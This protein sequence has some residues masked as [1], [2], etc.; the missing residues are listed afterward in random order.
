MIGKR[1]MRG[2]VAAVALSTLG[3]GVV[4]GSGSAA[5]S[6]SEVAAAAAPPGGAD[7]GPGGAA[8]GPGGVD[9]Q[10]VTT[11]DELV[12]LI[13]DAYGDAGLGLH[14]GHQPVESVLNEVLTI[15]HEELHVRMDSGQNLAAIAEDLGVGTDALVAALVESWS[16]AIDNL[17]ES[18]VITEAEATEYEAALTEAFTFRVTWN[19]TDETPTFTGIG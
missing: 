1:K 13:Q 2:V 10:S 15:S 19:G 3:A 17:A 4:S 14:R 6:T 12:A 9:P 5:G 11:V 8:A 18:G 7:G 16:P